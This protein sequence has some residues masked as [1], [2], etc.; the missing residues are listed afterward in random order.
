MRGLKFT[1]LAMTTLLVTACSQSDEALQS[2]TTGNPVIADK[3]LTTG[4]PAVARINKAGGT[5][6][7]VLV[8]KTAITTNDI[9]RRAA[10]VKL[11]RI[12]GNSSSVAKKELI[13][14]A[15]KMKE[16]RRIKAVVSDSDV[17]A[18]YVRFAKNNKMPV[19]ILTKILNERGVTQRGFKQYIRAQMSWQRAVGARLRATGGRPTPKTP[20]RRKYQTWLPDADNQGKQEDVYTLQQVVFIVPNSKR[21]TSLSRRTAEAKQFRT[22]VDGCTNAKTL[23]TSLKDVTVRDLGRVREHELPPRWAKDIKG[24]NA[25]TITRVQQTEKGAEFLAICNSRTVQST[26]PVGSE[27]LFNG[28]VQK[29]ASALEKTYLAELRERA[30][31]QER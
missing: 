15:I 30:V 12:K 6:I 2:S 22:R 16:A 20:E 14:E 31:I 18:A 11:R 29:Q 3:P 23:A 17:D 24:K 19:N 27:D 8:D 25:G 1:T 5:K 26:A 9:K 13:E 7:A 4:A 28:N 10:F 21:S